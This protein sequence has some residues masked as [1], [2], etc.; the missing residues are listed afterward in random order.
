MP[1]SPQEKSLNQAMLLCDS[2]RFNSTQSLTNQ[3]F[4]HQCLAETSGSILCRWE[5]GKRYLSPL[6]K[7]LPFINEP[8]F[9][10][11]P[12]LSGTSLGL[13]SSDWALLPMFPSLSL[14][15]DQVAMASWLSSGCLS[16]L[17]VS[18]FIPLCVCARTC[19]RVYVHVCTCYACVHICMYG[20]ACV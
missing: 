2:R 15:L 7:G 20:N 6:F 12:H 17:V 4:P 8:L 18:P 10:L 13:F 16:L 11:R 1:I 5:M 14:R 19:V 3:F 9:S